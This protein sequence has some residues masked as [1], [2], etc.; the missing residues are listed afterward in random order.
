PRLLGRLRRLGALLT[1]GDPVVGAVQLLLVV[2][3]CATPG[4]FQG[5]ASG[6]GYFGFMYLPGIVFHHPLDMGPV[7]PQWATILGRERTGRVA[8]ACPIGPVALWMPTYLL[9]LGLGRLC[10]LP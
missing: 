3:Y 8:N 2:Y 4:I 7:I 6:D 5:K 1:C 10:R 9:G